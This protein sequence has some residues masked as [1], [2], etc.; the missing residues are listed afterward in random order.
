M[1]TI[2][3]T[4][5]NRGIGLELAKRYAA[6]GWV[7]IACCRKPKEARALAAIRGEVEIRTLDV[8]KPASIARLKAALGKRPIDLLLNNAGVYGQRGGFGRTDPKDFLATIQVNSLAPL[9]LA[10]ALLPN[11]MKGGM[12]KIASITSKMGSIGDGP[13]GGGY[14]YRASKTA[15]NMVMANA[16]AEL[17]GKGI[18]VVVLHPGWVQTDMG[19]RNAPVKVGDSAA[20]IMRVI[21][22]LTPAQS[23]RFFNYDGSTIPW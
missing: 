9:L 14:A 6:A 10:E 21:D 2:L 22:G 23:G 17:K 4:G 20:G 13:G 1:P 7:V 19:G 12:K 16:A 5:A 11:L 15:L 18:S 3:I 8:A